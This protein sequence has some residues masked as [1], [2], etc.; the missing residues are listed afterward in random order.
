MSNAPPTHTPAT[1]KFKL[2]LMMFLQ[3]VIW[4]AWFEIG[5][6]YIPGLAFGDTGFVPKGWVLPL[7]F[8]AFNIGAL[9]ALFFS[10]Q[11]ADRNYAAE[12]F[13]SFSH[14]IGGLAILGLF[15]LHPD[16]GNQPVNFW[17][18]FGL[19]LLHSIFYVPTISITNSIA[20]TAMKDPQ[21]EFG[22]IR[23]WGTIG[24]IVASWPFIFILVDWSKVPAFG[25][26]GF[27]DWLGE[28][29]S[30][31]LS[32]AALA[33]GQSYVFLVAGIASLL[34]SAFSL[35]LPHTPPKPASGL[36]KF[37]WL[38]A[39]KYLAKPFLLVLFFV[40]FIDAAVH[41]S[42][43]FWTYDFLKDKVGIP[44]NWA[45]SV[46]K[47]GQIAEILTMLSLGYVLKNLGWRRTMIIGVLGHAARFAVFAYFPEKTPAILIIML[48]GVCYA[49]F[50]ATVYIFVDKYFP[51]DIRSSAQGLFNALIL[52]V[53]PFVAN[54]L[55]SEL[56]VKY[57]AGGVIDYPVVF[58][59]SMG[60]ALVGA[61]L[62]ALFFHPPKDEVKE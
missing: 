53:G 45:G 44:A 43:F 23:L 55:T 9:V 33:K 32:G 15:F 35:T 18:F 39:M 3:F 24:W 19:M 31:S 50:F 11:F 46:M 25:A 6:S 57:S 40:T 14:L 2:S 42:Y 20:F 1:L 48:H 49:F 28:A 56:K 22:P 4:G 21:K 26:V 8:G 58:Q 41:Q 52:G 47:I 13:L 5:F 16:G 29:F 37:A 62:L 54:F 38:K 60:A 12:K 59:Y 34:L 27:T 61:I 51:K 30:H 17:A 10:T 7:I 36:D